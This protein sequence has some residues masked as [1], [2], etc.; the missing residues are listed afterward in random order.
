MI[1]LGPAPF[2][3]L[4]DPLLKVSLSPSSQHD[5]S[6]DESDERTSFIRSAKSQR[7]YGSTTSGS[8]AGGMMSEAARCPVYMEHR[9]QP[10]DTLVSIALRYETTVSCIT[11]I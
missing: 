7:K 2:S 1:D 3:P 6:S 5:C 10:G 4:M 8:T 11:M 9:V